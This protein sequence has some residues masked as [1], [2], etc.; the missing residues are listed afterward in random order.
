MPGVFKGGRVCGADPWHLCILQLASRSVELPA[1]QADCG[2][3]HGLV[4]TREGR[5]L[6]ML[7]DGLQWE[8]LLYPSLRPLGM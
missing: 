3:V 4:H 8:L 6:M 2:L 7:R 1:G 5:F